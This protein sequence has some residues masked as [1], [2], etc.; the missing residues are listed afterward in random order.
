MKIVVRNNEDLSPAEIFG[1]LFD[2]VA[3]AELF[4]DEKSWAD[5]TYTTPPVT[6]LREFDRLKPM[7]RKDLNGFISRFFEFPDLVGDQFFD[8]KS[9][10]H[11]PIAQH[12]QSLWKTLTRQ[13]VPDGSFSS[14]IHL[15]KPYIVPGGR[16][17]EIYYWD[18]YFTMLAFERDAAEL[19]HMVENF[20]SLIRQFGFIPN[21]N[22]TYF[23]SRSQPPFFFKLLS[24]MN[25]DNPAVIY[26]QYIQELQA[27][28]NFWM[29]NHLDRPTHHCV[30]IEPGKFLNRYYDRNAT[31]RDESYLTDT[32]LAKNSAQPANQLFRNIR[33]GA[34]SG[35]DFS[36]RW[37]AETDKLET[38][39]TT[40][41]LPVDLNAILF[42]LETSIRDGLAFMGD[43]N[44]SAQF[45]DRARQRRELMTKYFWN[46]AEGAFFD[47][48]LTQQIQRSNR[49]AATFYP[50]FF[51]CA[52]NAQI[53][54]VENF[55]K[56]HLLKAGGL[57]TT[58]QH[59]HEQWD[60]PNGWAPLQWI[61]VKGFEAYGHT[62]T[63]SDIAKRWLETVSV[64]YNR[65]G[66]MYEKYDVMAQ[67][68]ATGGEYMV[69]W[70]F[71]WTNGV[72]IALMN[73][74]RTGVLK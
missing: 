56:E 51:G 1:E 13:D 39:K 49:T 8:N 71:G 54:R 9:E 24:L 59:S 14:Y 4:T 45:A 37:L 29:D 3:K 2:A 25:P 26:A 34:E 64:T 57:M 61:A 52:S 30:E 74:L 31:P 42:G 46:E 48:D 43:E 22:R 33:A 10:D 27:E 38:I 35:W 16:F 11:I 32:K 7:T 19:K 5:V 41:I 28:Y 15:P 60:A 40:H 62:E 65:T 72:T 68:E 20:A 18:S 73:Y 63:A 17:R 70:G 69:Q 67:K 66:R 55:T 53:A 21:G 6:I 12:I 47:F 36:S 23:L 44:Q 50:A 58:D